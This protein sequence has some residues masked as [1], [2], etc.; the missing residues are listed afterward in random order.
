MGCDITFCLCLTAYTKIRVDFH[1][2]A[3]MCAVQILRA[4]MMSSS[5]PQAYEAQYNKS[6]TKKDDKYGGWN[7]VVNVSLPYTNSAHKMRK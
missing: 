4:Q 7:D 3:Y 1:P 2:G 6:I 5:V